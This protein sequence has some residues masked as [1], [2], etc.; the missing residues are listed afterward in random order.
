MWLTYSFLHAGQGNSQ[1]F[2]KEVCC[3]PYHLIT[4]TPFTLSGRKIIQTTLQIVEIQQLDAKWTLFWDFLATHFHVINKNDILISLAESFS[5]VLHVLLPWHPLLTARISL[6][7]DID[8]IISICKWGT[9]GRKKSSDITTVTHENRNR[10]EKN[11]CL[12]GIKRVWRY[13]FF[14]FFDYW[15]KSRGQSSH[16]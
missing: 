14:L 5:N 12:S 15:K 6:K 1:P 11:D 10:N 2:R 7:L 3:L 8:I 9:W 4:T 13:E 16:C